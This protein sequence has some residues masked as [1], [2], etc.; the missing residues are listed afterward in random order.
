VTR[1]PIVLVEFSPS[2]GLFQ[3]AVQLGEAIAECGEPVVLL[4]GPDPELQSTQ[5]NFVIRPVL[6]TWHPADDEIK[7]RAFRTVRRAVRAAQLVLAWLVL[8]G[9]L[10]R[11]RPR[12]VLWSHWRFSFE[13]LF[14]VGISWIVRKSLFGIVAHEPLPRS[15]AKDTSTPKSGRLLEAAFGAAW[16]RM[17]VAFVLGPRTREVV[18]EHW[19]PR[20]E[21]VVVPHGDERVLRSS[22]TVSS[23]AETE[24]VAVF[25]G[26]WSTYKGVDVLLDAFATVRD[27][28]PDARLVLAG[29]VGADVDRDALLRRAEQIGHVDARPGYVAVADVAA[30]VESAR[31]LVTPYV[32]ASQSGVAHLA[33]TFARPVVASRIG[34]LPEVVR[35]GETGLLVPPGDAGAL[36]QAMIELLD[37]PMRAAELGD[38]GYR[39]VSRAWTVAAERIVAAVDSAATRTGRGR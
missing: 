37:D 33:F 6:P 29:A 26:T 35:D 23:A 5:E 39:S 21:V 15:D 28:L 19:Q 30:I 11:T 32:R 13:P 3:F 25:F 24:A 7:S 18:L 20:G 4:T 38:A 22:E 9:H 31:L 27:K 1:R 14:V 17:D 36:A 12:V 10:V 34:D 2:G 8:A 16:R